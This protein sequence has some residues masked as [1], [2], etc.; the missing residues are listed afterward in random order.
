MTKWT[1]GVVSI[2]ICVC[3]PQAVQCELLSREE[4]VQSLQQ[5]SSHILHVEQGEES[6]EAKEKVHVVYNKLRLLLRQ[7][8]HDLSTL[9]TRLVSIKL[10]FLGCLFMS[11]CT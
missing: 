7:I 9:K 1:Q 11:M 6:M 5:I 3:V 2:R 10:Y 8:S 4:E